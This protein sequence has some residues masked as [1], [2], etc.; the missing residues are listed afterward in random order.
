MIEKFHGWAATC[1]GGALEE[2]EY[3]VGP[4]TPQQVQVRVENC[5]ICHSDVSMLN[6]DW[7][8][9]NYPLV[10]GHEVVGVVEAVGRDV[11]NLN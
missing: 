11:R 8:M 5:G 2:I 4:L 9:T 7:G 1:P 6:N 10:P 3:E